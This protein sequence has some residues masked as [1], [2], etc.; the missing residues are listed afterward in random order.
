MNFVDISRKRK[1]LLLTGM[2]LGILLAALDASIVTTAMP[3]IVSDLKGL[4]QY[5][6]PMISYLLCITIAMPLVG[7]L[8]DV[9]GA[10]TVYLF[11]IVAFLIGSA[12]CGLAHDMLWLSFTEAYKVL[13]GQSSYPIRS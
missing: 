3:R 13:A 12:L 4:D 6:W 5:T 11:G 7:K 9:I 8:I 10:K 2:G 1:F